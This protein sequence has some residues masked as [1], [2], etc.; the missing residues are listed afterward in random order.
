MRRMTDS[1][2]KSPLRLGVDRASSRVARLGRNYRFNNLEV[3][4]FVADIGLAS[5]R[6][7]SREYQQSTFRPRNTLRIPDRTEELFSDLAFYWSV[8]QIWSSLAQALRVSPTARIAEIGCGHVPKVA[9]GF[10]YLGVEGKVDLV[11]NDAIA[12]ERASR[13]LQ[14][15]G[16]RF[17]IGVLQG[18]LFDEG[19][20]GYDCVFA[21]HLLDDLILDHFCKLHGVDAAKL[22]E[23]EDNYL[24]VWGDIIATPHLLDDF[25]PVLADTLVT[26]VR[27]G[28][29]VLLLDYPS[30]SH[31]ALGLTEV[32]GLVRKATRLLRDAIRARGGNIVTDLPAASI[33][34]DRITVT[35]DD[36]VAFRRGGA[37]DEL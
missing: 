33:T 35:Q 29:V 19:V 37:N 27:P 36:I 23:R 13:F 25:V 31:R 11:D 24:E 32:I 15:I 18:T 6:L 21:N 22:Y 16:A 12:L 17:P 3:E 10:H 2:L 26:K 34:V 20:S 30:F 1:P 14:L 5:R 7:I 28:G 8:G 9:I 4:R